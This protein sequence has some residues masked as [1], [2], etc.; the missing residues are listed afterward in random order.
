MALVCINPDTGGD[1]CGKDVR[2]VGAN[3]RRGDAS[4]HVISPAA[5]SVWSG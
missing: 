3:E 2:G 1:N 4:C 5:P